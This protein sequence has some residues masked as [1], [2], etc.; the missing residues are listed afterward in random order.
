MSKAVRRRHSG[1]LRGSHAVEQRARARAAWSGSGEAA[2]E[3]VWFEIKEKHR[4]LR[5]PRLLP[6]KPPKPR[7]WPLVV[8]G[9]RRPTAA[10]IGAEVAVRAQPDPFLRRK[11]WPA[12][13]HR[14]HQRPRRSAH[15]RHRHPEETWR[16]VRPSRPR[17][18]RH[19]PARHCPSSPPSTT[20]GAATSAPTTP[21][22]TS[23]TRRCAA[24]LAPTWQQKG[25]LNAPDRLRF[26]VSQPRPIT[27]DELHWVEAEVNHRIREN[28]EVTTR[29]MTPEAAV[30]LGAMALF[31]EKYGEEVRVV[32]MGE[33]RMAT[34]AHGRSS[35]AAAPMSAA[36]AIS[37]IFELSV[38]PPSPP[39]C[40]G[41]R[42]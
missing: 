25:S 10:H 40:A 32:A 19:R 27:A 33:L 39:A 15:H 37:A 42:R 3:R 11:R 20:P 22:P 12:R 9:T 38:R 16:P 2:T 7:F 36:P 1:W 30:E 6:P 41:S 23:C 18:D 26:D 8:D 13:R 17:R 24:S 31:G 5:V 29:L 14:R 21:P 4:R 34:R 35:Y 28:S